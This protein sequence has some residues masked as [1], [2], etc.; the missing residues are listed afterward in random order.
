M[1]IDLRRRLKDARR[2]P[3]KRER[4]LIVAAV[5]LTWNRSHGSGC[6]TRG[7]LNARTEG[8]K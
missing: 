1:T 7:R 8:V 5:M 2:H 4:L 3:R 6:K